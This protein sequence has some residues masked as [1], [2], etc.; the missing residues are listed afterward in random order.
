MDMEYWELL[1][2]EAI[3]EE[4]EIAYRDI[5]VVAEGEDGAPTPVSLEMLGK[6][7]ELADALG[8]YVQSAVLGEGVEGLAQELIETIW[9]HADRI[10]VKVA[11]APKLQVL[12]HEV[13]LKPALPF[14]GVG[15]RTRTSTS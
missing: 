7:R 3:E 5:W 4:Q 12:L 2:G 11:G 8:A 14:R 13:G 9:V 1:T 6:A 15:E 10:E